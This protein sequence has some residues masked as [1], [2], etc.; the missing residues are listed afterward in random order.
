MRLQFNFGSD[1]LSKEGTEENLILRSYDVNEV[2]SYLLSHFINNFEEKL[3]KYKTNPNDRINR[4]EI[5]Q[6]L[7]EALETHNHYSMKKLSSL[8]QMIQD[9][10]EKSAKD[11]FDIETLQQKINSKSL[12]TIKLIIAG[13]IAQFI[14]LYYVTYYVAGWDLGEPIS[15]LLGIML[16]IIGSRRLH[17]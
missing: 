4:Q 8:N 11:I 16:E 6:I 14:G 17:Q 5:D 9:L 3:K 1:A 15:Y 10:T 2:N 7:K 12:F 13:L